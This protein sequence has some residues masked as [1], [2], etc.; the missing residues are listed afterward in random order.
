MHMEIEQ[1]GIVHPGK[2]AL[3]DLVA[4]VQLRLMWS[5]GKKTII[6]DFLKFYEVFTAAEVLSGFESDSR[7]TLKLCK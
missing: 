2:E 5:V 4:A 1:N 3:R 6:C 7:N